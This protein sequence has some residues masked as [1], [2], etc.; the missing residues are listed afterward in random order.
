MSYPNSFKEW[1][2]GSRF[3]ALRRKQRLTQSSL[4]KKAGVHRNTV[5]NT[6]RNPGQVRLELLRKQAS[7]LG[8]PLWQILRPKKVSQA[9]VQNSDSALIRQKTLS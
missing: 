2:P 5:S 6:E 3:K 9:N 7:V 8:K 1:N 4:A